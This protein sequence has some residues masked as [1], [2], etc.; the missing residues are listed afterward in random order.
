MIGHGGDG[1]MRALVRAI[2]RLS[3]ALGGV[4][5]VIVILLVVLML[6][7]VVMRYAFNAPTVWGNDINT[8]LMG[9][10]FVFSI[11]Y[12]MST[13]SH[14]R[15]DLLYDD[16]TKHRMRVVDLIGF[17][18]LVLPTVGWLSWGLFGHFLDAVKSGERSGTGGWNPI[19]WPFRLVLFVGFMMLTIQIIAEIIKRASSL[20][21]RPIE[22][23]AAADHGI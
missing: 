9:T 16:T 17:T 13:D 22:T 8:W 23:T 6:Y 11:A 19:V 14:V 21:G 5:A 2:D 1:S 7:D 3:V 12:A 15:V 10:S 20:A 18:F 4:A